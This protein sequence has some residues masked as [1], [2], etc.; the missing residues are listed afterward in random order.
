MRMKLLLAAFLAAAIA[1]TAHAS[2]SKFDLECHLK[3]QSG[4]IHF[5][6]AHTVDEDRGGSIEYYAVD[7][8][9]MK[10]RA[11][12]SSMGGD[13]PSRPIVKLNSDNIIFSNR[14]GVYFSYNRATGSVQQRIAQDNDTM[15]IYKGRC[16]ERSYSKPDG[17]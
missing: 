11:L 7:L 3:E 15:V 10:Y 8:S 1:Q 5:N 9:T 14:N 12:N 16:S 17:G 4:H 13:F 2:P 6:G